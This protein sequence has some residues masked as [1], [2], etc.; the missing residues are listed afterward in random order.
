MIVSKDSDFEQQALLYGHPPKVLWLR[1]GNCQTT[2][3]A[4]L[5]RARR[6]DVLAFAADPEAAVLALA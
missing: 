3:V 5:L 1:V 6:Q 2:A 4:A